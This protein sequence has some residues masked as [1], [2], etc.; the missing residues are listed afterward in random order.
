[1][2]MAKGE[3]IAQLRS[4]LER[5]QS[6]E[7]PDRYRHGN[8]ISGGYADDAREQGESS[9]VDEIETE[10]GLAFGGRNGEE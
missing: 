6:Y 1:M 10:G 7:L 4:A 2:T 8:D 3:N 9:R 5:L